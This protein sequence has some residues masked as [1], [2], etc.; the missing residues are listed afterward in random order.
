[1]NKK[2]IIVLALVL[3]TAGLVFASGDKEDDQDVR[4][5]YGRGPRGVM[6][7]GGGYGAPCY[8]SDF[9]FEEVSL[10]GTVDFTAL[11]TTLSAE[12]AEWLLMYPRWALA[13][14]EIS[15]GDTVSVTGVKTPG[16]RFG[17]D[18]GAEENYLM[19]FSAEIDGETY[20]L[21]DARGNGFGGMGGGFRPMHGGRGGRRW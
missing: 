8:D 10:T 19:V 9:E 2:G 21:S 14:V 3:M 15:S 1:M 20:E 7:Y 5:G 4:P 11:G 6:P 12:G 13:D 16:Y 18:D 17:E